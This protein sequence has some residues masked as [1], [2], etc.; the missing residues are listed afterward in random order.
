MSSGIK[1]CKET[2]SD[3]GKTG[4][5]YCVCAAGM[6]RGARY[7]VGE[8]AG[9]TF[10]S[11]GGWSDSSSD[12]DGDGGGDVFVPVP[13]P[14]PRV[15]MTG[16]DPST[17]LDGNTR[18]N[19]RG[20]AQFDFQETNDTCSICH[21]DMNV[22]PRRRDYRG[23]IERRQLQNPP[24]FQAFQDYRRMW[25]QKENWKVK[26][27]APCPACESCMHRWCAKSVLDTRDACPLCRLSFAEVLE[28]AGDP[29]RNSTIRQYSDLLTNSGGSTTVREYMRND[30]A[31]AEFQFE[32]H[33][34]QLVNVDP[35]VNL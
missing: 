19:A 9:S 32:G 31:R 6:R 28:T 18:P 30:L 7:V 4:R 24:S 8:E 21:E 26:T 17:R 34:V 14:P 35:G 20:E 2:I 13:G 10:V 3:C 27:N 23:E 22:Y 1:D 11:V 33:T 16:P 15:R 12:S 29:G 25:L 5:R